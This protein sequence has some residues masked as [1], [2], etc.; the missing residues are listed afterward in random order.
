MT[1]SNKPTS[2]VTALEYYANLESRCDTDCEVATEALA[3]LEAIDVAGLED[4]VHH[5]NLCV[6]LKNDDV[7]FIKGDIE[8]R[9]LE[10][11]RQALLTLKRGV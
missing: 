10:T 7:A 5:L 6:E 3:Q 9:H 1:Q 2:I 4:A 8:T 11:I